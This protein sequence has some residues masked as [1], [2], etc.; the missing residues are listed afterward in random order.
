MKMMII[1][2]VNEEINCCTKQTIDGYESDDN[3]NSNFRIRISEKIN[4]LQHDLIINDGNIN[5]TTLVV[6]LYEPLA[7]VIYIPKNHS[8]K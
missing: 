5:T 3:K 1:N 4:K 7:H 6:S 8:L 2:S